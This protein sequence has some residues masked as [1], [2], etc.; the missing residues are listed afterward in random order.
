MSARREVLQAV[1]IG[2]T[3]LVALSLAMN[4][5]AAPLPPTRN[6]AAIEFVDSPP[7]GL[8]VSGGLLGVT[9]SSGA[10][11]VPYRRFDPGSG[12]FADPGRAVGDALVFTNLRPGTY[13]LALVFLAESKFATRLLPKHGEKF[14]DRCMVYSDT[15]PE[16]TFT[17]TN[18]EVR[19]L[20]R[21]IRRVLPN[22][23]GED[24]CRSRIEWTAG[25]ERRAVKSLSKHKDMAPWQELLGARQAVLDSTSAKVR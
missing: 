14:V 12:H 8:A 3:V 21:V 11:P 10:F 5:R 2:V 17:I 16:L 18:G 1:V 24:H 23:S 25:D 19:Y 6:V 20:G 22:L 15:I 7:T 13:R 9:D 4:G